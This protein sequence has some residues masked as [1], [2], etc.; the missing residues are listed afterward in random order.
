MPNIDYVPISRLNLM[1]PMQVYICMW[2]YLTISIF[3]L[4]SSITLLTSMWTTL[5]RLFP[6]SFINNVWLW[7]C[8]FFSWHR[9][10]IYKSTQSQWLSIHMDFSDISFMHFGFGP[11]HCLCRWL[12][13]IEGIK[14]I[15]LHLVVPFLF[16]THL[17]LLFFFPALANKWTN[18]STKFTMSRSMRMA[19]RPI[20]RIT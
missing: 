10:S 13:H 8:F 17:S 20:N 19:T 7:I 9:C 1:K 11:G 4:I 5:M 16:F 3:W 2:I 6:N 14:R 15:L 18:I 12:R